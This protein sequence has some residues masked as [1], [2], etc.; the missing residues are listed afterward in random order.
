[1]L[2]SERTEIPM[3]NIGFGY[4]DPFKDLIRSLNTVVSLLQSRKN[5]HKSVHKLFM[6]L[7]LFKSDLT[8]WCRYIQINIKDRNKILF[9]SINYIFISPLKLVYLEE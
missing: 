6:E 3:I 9:I 4:F 7:F 2:L 5:C 8:I 1:M